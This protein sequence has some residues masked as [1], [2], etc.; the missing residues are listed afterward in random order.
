M[1]RS[2][3]TASLKSVTRPVV[4]IGLKKEFSQEDLFAKLTPAVIRKLQT[5]HQTS[6]AVLIQV[7]KKMFPGVPK[8]KK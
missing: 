7:E 6:D 2:K 4:R 8:A 1:A 3:K 5:A